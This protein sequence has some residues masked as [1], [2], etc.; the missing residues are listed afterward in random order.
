MASNKGKFSE[1][2]KRILFLR[3][4]K[5]TKKIDN[6]MQIED[7]NKIYINFLKVMAAI[8]GLVYGNLTSNDSKEKSNNEFNTTI[9]T[10]NLIKPSI[11]DNRHRLKDNLNNKSTSKNISNSK[12]NKLDHTHNVAANEAYINKG[13]I[14][15][16]ASFSKIEENRNTINDNIPFKKSEINKDRDIK[17]KKITD[18]SIQEIKDK[19][20]KYFKSQSFG[21]NIRQQD[22]DDNKVKQLEKS[23]VNLIKKDLIKVVN[24]LEILQSELYI[25]SEVNG[26]SKELVECQRELDQVKS[27]LCKIDKLK[28]QYDFL[29]DNYDFEYLLE[30][31]NKDLVDKIIEL[32]DTFGDNKLKAVSEDY[33]LLDVYKYLYLKIDDLQEKTALFEEKKNQEAEKLKARDINFESLK[34]DVYNVGNVNANYQLF[35]NNQNDLLKEIDA[36]VSKID[37]YEQVDYH[38]KGF[39]EIFRSTFKYFGL[40]MVSPLKGI[41]PSIATETLITGNLIKNLYKK[42]E[43]EETRTMVYEAIDYSKLISN[44]INDLESTSNIVDMTLDDI[45]HLKMKYNEQFKKYQ[46]DFLE[47]REIMQ[48][49]NDMENKI[50]GN[51]IKIEMMKKRALEQQKANEKKL[52]LVKELN[53]K[54]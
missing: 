36:N 8:P 12:N 33:K 30:I 17:R 7:S 4:N 14:D 15:N 28:E 9:T 43:W 25:L 40:L 35:V 48:R 32:K 19:Q 18:I 23:I 27:M 49:I 10:S 24:E 53:E 46:G 41:I 38:L 52:K 47:Y 42:L 1:R 21:I 54:K 22:N 16:N 34:R 3:R 29:K 44:A 5:T 6:N 2:L 13:N 50:L 39:S 26:E 45:V 31:D 11:L 20:D 37:S 51:K